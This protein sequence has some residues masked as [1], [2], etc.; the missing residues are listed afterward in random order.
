MYDLPMSRPGTTLAVAGAATDL[1][2]AAA[3]GLVRATHS[4]VGLRHVEGP[5]PTV[6]IVVALAAPGVLALVGVAIRR[7]IL[8]GAAGFAC[9]PLIIVSVIAFP[10]LVAGGLLI[11]AFVRAQTAKLSP[12]GVVALIFVTFPVTVALGLRTL[13]LQTREF[14]YTFPGGSEGGEYFTPAHA[15][16]CIAFVVAGIAFVATLAREFVDV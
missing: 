5:L 11:A 16:V 6:A 9:G 2:L 3:L 13:I 1:V 14:T 8:F 7:P 15:V 10:F 4:S 12:G